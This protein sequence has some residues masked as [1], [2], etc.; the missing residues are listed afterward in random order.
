MADVQGRIVHDGDTHVMEVPGLLGGSVEARSQRALMGAGLFDRRPPREVAPFERRRT[1]PRW[2]AG[3]GENTLLRTNCDAL[4]ACRREDRPAALDQLGFASQR[5]FTTQ[6]LKYLADIEH[7][8][9]LADDA[10]GSAQPVHGAFPRSRPATPG[11]GHRAAQAQEAG[12]PV[13]FRVGGGGTL[14]SPDHVDN[15]L[16][17]VP[18]FHGGDDNFRS[19]D[20]LAIPFPPMQSLATMIIDGVHATSKARPGC[21]LDADRG[22]GAHGVLQER[23]AFAEDAAKTERVRP[24]PSA[25]DTLSA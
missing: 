4:G 20:H 9:D 11:N 15:G 6:L 19:V 5:V 3:D 7:G 8:E 1:D 2:R 24:P 22:F 17:P 12:L 14:L 16:P 10:G 18:D 21:R 25:G 23:G 13:V